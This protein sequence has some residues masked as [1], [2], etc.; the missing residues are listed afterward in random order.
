ML[1]HQ[2][3]KDES[4]LIQIPQESIERRPG[5]ENYNKKISAI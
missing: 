2:E 4:T 3:E 1:I 5:N